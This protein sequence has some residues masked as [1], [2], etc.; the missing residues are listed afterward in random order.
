M[1]IYIDENM[2]LN[3]AEGLNQLQIPLTLRLGINV[4]VKSIQQFLAGAPRT[5]IGFQVPGKKMLVS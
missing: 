2:P 4:E 1:I 3:L 5:R